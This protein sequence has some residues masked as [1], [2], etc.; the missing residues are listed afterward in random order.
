MFQKKGALH[1]T[2]ENTQIRHNAKIHTKYILLK[3]CGEEVF[4]VKKWNL[5]KRIGVTCLALLDSSLH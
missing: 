4:T 5:L 2:R 3:Y 1:Y